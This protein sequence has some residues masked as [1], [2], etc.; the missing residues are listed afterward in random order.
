MRQPI[1]YQ[2][3][4][5]QNV[6]RKGSQVSWFDVTG[7]C[8]GFGI[9][10]FASASAFGAG[11]AGL[12]RLR[13]CQLSLNLAILQFALLIAGWFLGVEAAHRMGVWVVWP[14]TI[15]VLLV[16]IKMSCPGKPSHAPRETSGVERT[17]S[18]LGM[19]TS[20]KTVVLVWGFVLASLNVQQGS[21][22]LLVGALAFMLTGVGILAGDR[23][24]VHLPQGLKWAGACALLLTAAHMQ[25][26]LLLCS[27]QV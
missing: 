24:R 10:V 13:A 11:L 23:F 14:D 4:A 20:A 7:L 8:L 18:L 22:G 17:M 6:R 9:D 19:T 15:F 1:T 12:S 5:P 27:P 2:G 16:A 25:A 26:S 3:R 21:M